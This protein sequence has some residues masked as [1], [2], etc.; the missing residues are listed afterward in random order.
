MN[1]L[2]TFIYLRRLTGKASDNVGVTQVFCQLNAAG[3]ETAD[4]ANGWTN[5]T[6][7]VAPSPGA[8]VVA[9]YAEDAAG[10]RSK[11]NSVSFVYHSSAPADWAPGSL[12]GLLAELTGTVDT[13]SFTLSFGAGTFSQSMFP[14]TNENQNGIGTYSYAKLSTNVAVLTTVSTA[15]PDRAGHTNA[16]TLTFTNSHTAGFIGTNSEGAFITGSLRFSEA[17]DLAPAS[18]QGKTLH[19]GNASG[20]KTVVAF[21]HGTFTATEQPGQTPSGTYTF[22]RY[23]PVGALL[24]LN[25]TS[26]SDQAG[27]V[28][29]VVLTFS[30][31]KTGS[32]FSITYDSPGAEPYTDSGTFT[33]P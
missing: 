33:L 3:W 11:T 14:G 27:T 17:A 32:Y 10:N 28:H 31:A 19:G 18:I 21:G 16:L 23:S 7:Q 6:A 1:Q 12:S 4:S 9:A 24:Q 22:T 26:P 5:W 30:T 25:V 20:D 13:N 29:Y 15:P 2:D 8:N